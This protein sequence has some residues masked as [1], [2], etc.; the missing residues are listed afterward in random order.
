MD[1]GLKSHLKGL[2]NRTTKRTIV[3]CMC[4]QQRLRSVC[5][6]THYIKQASEEGAYCTIS[7]GSDQNVTLVI[8]V[9]TAR[10]SKLNTISECSDQNMQ[11]R[12]LT[13][14]FARST[15]R[16]VKPIDCRRYIRLAKALIRLLMC[17]LSVCR[18]IHLFVQVLLS[19]LPCTD[20]CA[21]CLCRP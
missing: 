19:V 21:I 14:V 18:L 15:R 2:M 3:Q 7:E 11:L 20:P 6:S 17:R 8:P 4:D 13:R 5:S 10:L 16:F 9:W 1:L 12:R